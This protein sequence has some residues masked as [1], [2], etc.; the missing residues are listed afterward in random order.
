MSHTHFPVWCGQRA[1][2]QEPIVIQENVVAFPRECLTMM[3]PMYEW[4]FAVLD[5][6]QY[7]WPIRRE[8]QFMMHLALTA[9]KSHI[10]LRLE[11]L[12]TCIY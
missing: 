10:G 3:L 7:G 9:S 11:L 2:L 5:P 4:V 8:R 1:I 6:S 12:N